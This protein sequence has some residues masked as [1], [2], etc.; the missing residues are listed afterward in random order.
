MA[1]QP[2]RHEELAPSAWIERFAAHV[3]AG[4]P[5]L[6]VAAGSGRHSRFFVRR[7][8]PVVAIDRD[9]TALQGMAGIEVLTADLEGGNPWP[10]G[11]QRFGGVVV[12]NYLHRPIL[13]AIVA[14]VAPGGALLYETFAIGNE[15]FGK[16]S[17]PDFL[18]RPGELLEAVRGRLRVIAYE[19]LEI[20]S[21]RPAMVQRIAAVNRS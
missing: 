18:L 9:T 11:A 17:N 6:D 15:R 14:A 19:D 2:G 5:V 10:L 12:T 13:G 7:G 8:H 20:S 21:P 1:S 4:A 3:P 16:P